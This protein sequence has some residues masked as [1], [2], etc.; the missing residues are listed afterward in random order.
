MLLIGLEQ[1]CVVC[2]SMSQTITHTACVLAR[3]GPSPAPRAACGAE[4]RTMGGGKAACGLIMLSGLAGVA[5]IQQR[6]SQAHIEYYHTVPER[7]ADHS[8]VALPPSS[9]PSNYR[10]SVAPFPI[11]SRRTLSHPRAF[12]VAAFI[13][14]YTPSRPLLSS[15]LEASSSIYDTRVAL[16]SS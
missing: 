8:A 3:P 4:A 11:A 12:S 16:P 15:L 7:S 5:N 13:S 2:V 1:N 6:L 9:H 14:A 10:S